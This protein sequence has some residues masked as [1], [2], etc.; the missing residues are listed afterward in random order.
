[1]FEFM[2]Q[3][4][5]TLSADASLAEQAHV[6]SD[7][8]LLALPVVDEKSR[9]V[10]AMDASDVIRAMESEYTAGMY[11]LAGLSAGETAAQTDTT[12][13]GYRT[14]WL[15]GNLAIAF[16]LAWIISSFA[17]MIAG[18]ALLVAF[19]PLAVRLASQAGMQSL[20]FMVH[21]LA[22][23]QVSADNQRQMMHREL[24]NGL[25]NGLLLGSVAGLLG[26]LWQGS[27]VLGLIIGVA[28]LINLLLASLAGAGVPLLFKALRLNPGHMSAMVVTTLTDVCGLGLLLGLATLA[29]HGGYL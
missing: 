29:L 23:G 14:I 17:S 24:V 25:M 22:L 12:S 4:Q 28:V 3:R 6:I 9:L 2:D 21:S 10:G 8:G 27:M 19:I 5:I 1:L 7:S 16:M 11:H 18:A 20:T 13:A 26:G 15:V